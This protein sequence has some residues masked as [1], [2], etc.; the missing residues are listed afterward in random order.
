MPAAHRSSEHLAS[1]LASGLKRAR[2]GHRF[3]GVKQAP[4]G[5]LRG[6]AMPAVVLEVGYITNDKELEVLLDPTTPESVA[7][8]ILW[9]LSEL[10]RRLASARKSSP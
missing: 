7:R 2:P 10:D 8:A 9:G 5:V 1:G 6:A 3:R 4:F